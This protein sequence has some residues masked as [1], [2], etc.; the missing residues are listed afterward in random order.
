MSSYY[1]RLLEKNFVKNVYLNCNKMVK[2]NL[3]SLE[4]HG[5]YCLVSELNG[6]LF[7]LFIL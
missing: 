7:L 6:K 2:Q 3:S 1:L 4:F 5:I